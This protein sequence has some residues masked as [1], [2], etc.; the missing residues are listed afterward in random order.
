MPHTQFFPQANHLSQLFFVTGIVKLPIYVILKEWNFAF[1]DPLVKMEIHVRKLGVS[2]VE[3]RQALFW[4]LVF[5][6][7]FWSR[8]TKAKQKN[9][10]TSGKGKQVLV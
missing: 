4:A 6:V 7:I 9:T 1:F 8:E 10:V 5:L 3:R 2:E